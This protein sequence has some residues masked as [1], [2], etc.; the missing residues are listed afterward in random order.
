MPRPISLI[1]REIRADWKKP[2]FGAGPYLDAMRYLDSIHDKYG[3]DSA[4]SII[5]YFLSNA[6]TWRGPAAR[7]IKDELK[8]ILKG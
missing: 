3:Y 4:G 8:A 7:R 1:A 5:R 6:A 2:Y